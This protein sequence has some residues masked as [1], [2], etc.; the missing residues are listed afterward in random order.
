[1]SAPETIFN[2]FKDFVMG[3]NKVWQWLNDP[4]ITLGDTTITPIAIFG[5]SG[6]LLVL[7]FLLVHFL[8][9]VN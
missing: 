9:P 2:I 7:A 6:L 8:N 1:M 4:L 3:I 5:V